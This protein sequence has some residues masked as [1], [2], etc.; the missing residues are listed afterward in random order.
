MALTFITTWAIICDFFQKVNGIPK[1]Y[2]I[3]LP[4]NVTHSPKLLD[5]LKCESEVKTTE[6]QKVWARSLACSILGVKG[7]AGALRWD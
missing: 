1:G 4:T 5:K 6:E 2:K 7:C 3:T